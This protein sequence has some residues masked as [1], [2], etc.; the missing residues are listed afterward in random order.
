VAQ[1]GSELIIFDAQPLKKSLD[2]PN[3][4]VLKLSRPLTEVA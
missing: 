1:E 3:T 2:H 4:F